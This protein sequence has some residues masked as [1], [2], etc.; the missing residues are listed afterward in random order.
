MARFLVDEDLPRSLGRGLR[1]EGFDAQD[2]RDIGLR[3]KTDREVLQ[4]AVAE[5]RILVTADL[6]FANLLAVPLG[7]HSGILVVRLPNE[8]AVGTVNTVVLN[9][10]RTLADEELRGSLMIV[11]PTRIRLRRP[12]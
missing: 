10:V 5:N 3:G 4:H 1:A 12:R 2:V 11:E 7:T 8:L 6:G 9:A